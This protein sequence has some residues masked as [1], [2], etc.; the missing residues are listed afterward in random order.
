VRKGMIRTTDMKKA[1]LSA[2]ITLIIAAL[3]QK[4]IEQ[5][6]NIVLFGAILILTIT[7]L[8]VI[9]DN[10]W[11]IFSDIE[12]KKSELFKA[13]ENLTKH[14]NDAL[15]RYQVFSD[16]QIKTDNKKYTEEGVLEKINEIRKAI[17]NFLPIA[18]KQTRNLLTNEGTEWLNDINT[19]VTYARIFQRKLIESMIKDKI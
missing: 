11:G 19:F 16:K 13:Y 10:V 3:M 9:Y 6:S 18:K 12:T 5:Y 8:G 1:I 2:G 15:Q 14:L 4:Y 7:I 17:N